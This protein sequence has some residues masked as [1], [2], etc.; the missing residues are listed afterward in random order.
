MALLFRFKDHITS[1]PN[2]YFEQAQKYNSQAGVNHSS[3]G[4]LNS[5]KSN[6]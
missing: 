2:F 4:I 3:G 1:I 5:S 6:R